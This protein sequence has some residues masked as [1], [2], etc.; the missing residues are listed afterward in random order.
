MRM[1]GKSLFF[2]LDIVIKGCKSTIF[3]LRLV[4]DKTGAVI[5]KPVLLFGVVALTSQPA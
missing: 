2:D 5:P 4:K 1:T 3:F